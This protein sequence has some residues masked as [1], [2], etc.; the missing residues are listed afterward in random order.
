M[1]KRLP[2]LPTNLITK[3]VEVTPEQAFEWLTE[4]NGIN[5]AISN[6]VVKMYAAEMRRGEWKVTHQGP[7]FDTNGNLIDGQHRLM[8]VIETGMTIPMYITLNADPDTFSVLDQNYKRTAAHMVTGKNR[9][10]K[11]AAARF[12]T[13]PPRLMY[14]GRLVNRDVVEIVNSHPGLE[15]ATEIAFRIYHATRINSTQMAALLT[16]VI[17]E[18]VPAEVRH[19]WTEGLVTGAG[20][21]SG[22]PR[23][24]L[25]N[26]FAAQGRDLN[27]AGARMTSLYLIIRAWNAHVLGETRRAFPVRTNLVPSDVPTPILSRPDW[28]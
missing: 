8:A 26:R 25:R 2:N 24:S 11:A 17:E 21:K 18:G 22:D 10:M 23:L 14:T 20:L 15:A 27:A 6:H 13:D 4:N 3:L 19:Q 12:L 9:S 28:A 5:R 1:T 7:A 16:L